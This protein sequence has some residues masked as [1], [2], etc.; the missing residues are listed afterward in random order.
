MKTILLV[1]DDSARLIGLSMILRSC[2]YAVLEAGNRDEAIHTCLAHSEPIQVLL[3]DLEPRGD[4][5]PLLA[6]RL[7]AMSPEMRVLFMIS[8][9]PD[10][11]VDNRVTKWTGSLPDGR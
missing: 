7:L 5:V 4:G 2:G 11:P 9:P 10:I 8:S 1:E 3:T 6:E